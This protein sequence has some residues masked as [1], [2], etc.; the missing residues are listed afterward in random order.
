MPGW[1]RTGFD[2][3]KWT[4]ADLVEPP[5]GTLQSQML[6]PMRI[7]EIRKPVAI[8]NPKPDQYVVDMGQAYYGTVRL[9]VSGPAGTKEKQGER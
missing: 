4:G 8:T 1:S 7:V 9:K 6:E 2:D 5:G 3:S